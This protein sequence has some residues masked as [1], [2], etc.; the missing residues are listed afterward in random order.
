MVVPWL[1]LRKLSW[2]S[3][4]TAELDIS[5]DQL[6]LI[7]AFNS[8]HTSSAQMPASGQLQAKFPSSSLELVLTL[9]KL[10]RSQALIYLTVW[11][12]SWEAMLK[13]KSLVDLETFSVE[14]CLALD[15]LEATG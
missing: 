6:G 1:V 4:V 10:A 5:E 15:I 3:H 2:L 12:Y 8:R 13:Q 7:S 9:L 11:I 14:H